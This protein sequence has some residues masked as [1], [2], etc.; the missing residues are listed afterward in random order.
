MP[1]P[2]TLQD[3][4]AA[5]LS[6]TQ[7]QPAAPAQPDFSTRTTPADGVVDMSNPASPKVDWL[8]MAVT[9][10]EALRFQPPVAIASGQAQVGAQPTPWQNMGIRIGGGIAGGVAGSLMGPVGTA[11]GAALGT[12]LASN[13]IA[14][15]REVQQ[16]L[17]PGVDPLVG[18]A[19]GFSTM[20]PV[21]A[22]DRALPLLRQVPRVMGSAA[23]GSA[24][25]S[26]GVQLAE[27]GSVDPMRTL[28]E[29]GLGTLMAGG[30]G[31]GVAGVPRVAQSPAVRRL[32]ADEAG[33]VGPRQPQV[34]PQPPDAPAGGTLE[35]DPAAAPLVQAEAPPAPLTPEPTGNWSRIAGEDVGVRGV[36]DDVDVPKDMTPRWF[37]SE[38]G[39]QANHERSFRF[40]DRHNVSDDL[41]QI[42]KDLFVNGEDAAFATQ[43]RMG[44]TWDQLD[45]EASRY[46]PE[47][48]LPKGSIVSPEEVAALRRST[49]GLM[50]RAATLSEDVRT[51]KNLDAALQQQS[52]EAMAAQSDILARHGVRTTQALLVAEKR[53]LEEAITAQRSLMGVRSEFGRGLNYLKSFQDAR[54]MDDAD[55]I[56]A[57]LKGGA[58]SDEV[59]AALRAQPNLESRY[60]F[61]R[62]LRKPQAQDYWRWYAMTAYLS[63]PVTQWRN[64][65]GN[66]SN[67]GVESVLVNPIA[68]GMDAV[69]NRGD[70]TITL[71]ENQAAAAG[72]ASGFMDGVGKA[73]YYF[74]HGFSP[75]EAS[76][77]TELPPEVFG[78][79][80]LPNVVGRS[81]GAADQFFRTVGL[82]MELHRQAMLDG[83]KQG[84]KGDDL[85]AY[86]AQQIADPT[87]TPEIHRRA[88]RYSAELTFQERNLDG[89]AAKIGG[90]ASL[91]SKG[92][93]QATK[94]VADFAWNH[95][96]HKLNTK[97]AKVG[98]ATYGLLSFPPSV[99]LAPFINTPLNILKRA[100]QYTPPAMAM[101]AKGGDRDA[102][103][104]AA[105][106]AVGTAA[107]GA[108]YGLYQQGLITGAAPTDPSERDLY[109]ATKRPYSLR[110]GD[111]WVPYQALG[112]VGM[113][114]GAATNYFKSAE[115]NPRDALGKAGQ[116][117]ASIGKT[118][119]DASF[120]KGIYNILDAVGNYEQKGDTWAAR[121]TMGLLPAAG[122][123][124]FVR[125]QID[126]TLRDPDGWKEQLQASLPGA[127]L[128][129]KPRVDYAGQDIKRTPSVAPSPAKDDPVRAELLRLRTS[130][131][132]GYLRD[133]SGA[134][135]SLVGKMNRRLAAR[136]LPAK[137]VPQA[138][139]TEYAHVYGRV[140]YD[141]FKALLEGAAYQQASDEDKA[142]MIRRAKDRLTERIDAAFIQKFLGQ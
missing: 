109:Y 95:G 110:I 8:A 72:M 23:G 58:N 75:D 47:I 24:A 40:L 22:V 49:F 83:T 127:S 1:P 81:M 77:L 37:T 27:T 6:A 56:A 74:R 69:R 15:P 25:G 92:A 124:R 39:K 7:A 94:S 51:L 21:K 26:V 142:T 103:R 18:V 66:A 10:A 126:P 114:L 78:G 102:M 48:K 138:L 30:V 45:A 31:L 112:P 141:V 3:A 113:V 87:I 131:G 43:R 100:V 80:L 136:G 65:M 137:E 123:Q 29:T 140:S 2:S 120:L 108:V 96:L 84:L 73:L 34:L 79:K 106:G 90:A 119:I 53:A 62:S 67:F 88:Q 105:R 57:A 35:L 139:Q 93:D 41:K 133:P 68:A 116:V 121:T 17:R 135:T 115:E 89:P 61:I 11:A 98:S 132:E 46:V 129:V 64:I 86:V 59:M 104:V 125:D 85:K 91:L 82:H 16:G 54:A 70:R 33:M 19:E 107:I 76:S 9:G 128:S 71:S 97:Y 101:A 111:Q 14:Q 13:E 50:D 99:I 20:L 44:M 4:I 5:W 55:F 28:Q 12:T 117:M 38:A 63:G 118:A 134:A 42:A 60:K 130:E 36:L 122:A 32:M 52:P